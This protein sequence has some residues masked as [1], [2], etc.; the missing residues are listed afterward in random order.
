MG[1]VPDG[2]YY[3]SMVSINRIGIPDTIEKDS[4]VPSAARSTIVLETRAGLC[5]VDAH[6]ARIV[7]GRRRRDEAVG[8]RQQYQKV[9]LKK[10]SRGIHYPHSLI[11]R[12]SISRHT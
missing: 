11:R 8:T 9:K 6:D 2:A 4:D 5:F 7:E 1:L 10:R 3:T 12:L